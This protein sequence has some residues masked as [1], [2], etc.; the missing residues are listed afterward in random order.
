MN[1]LD[2]AA[3][4]SMQLVLDSLR[5]LLADRPQPIWSDLV[6]LLGL[7][8]LLAPESVGGLGG[9]ISDTALLMTELGPA[10]AGADWL[11]HAAATLLLASLAEEREEIGLL[12]KGELRAALV[13]PATAASMPQID[14]DGALRGSA[15]LVSGA[16]E[17][18][19]LV[20]A[21]RNAT[22]LVQPALEGLEQRHRIML[23]GTVVADLDFTGR[24]DR[25]EIIAYQPLSEEHAS[26]INEFVLAAR[27]AEAVGL[28]DRM[29]G[30]TASFL[31]ERRQFGQ[32]IANFQA[33]R[34]RLA[35][36]EI[37]RMR[38]AALT[39]AAVAA[40]ERGSTDRERVVSAACIEV[41]DAVR[42]VGEGAVQLH[43]AMGLTEELRLGSLFKRALV[44]AAA[45][46][47]PRH[48]MAR[49]AEA[50]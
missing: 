15:S 45:L 50:A 46:G 40:V 47:R 48:H 49:F 32:P 18:N 13:C 31:V 27:C 42:L 7:G 21:G 14:K 2:I 19:I 1:S 24:Q 4:E 20:V 9:G 17:A 39:E 30:D 23:D 5:R 12:A 28:M 38:A 22:V 8:S 3:G 34:H 11:S 29:I 36:M 35:D 43:G 16:A 25:R 44:I 10:L 41:V 33:L 37:A 6:D 26:A